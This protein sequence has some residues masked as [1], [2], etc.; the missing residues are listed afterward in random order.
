MSDGEVVGLEQLRQE[1]QSRHCRVSGPQARAQVPRRRTAMTMQGTRGPDGHEERQR[2]N[3]PLTASAADTHVSARRFLD[4][5]A[6]AITEKAVEP[7]VLVVWDLVTNA[8]R[9]AAESAPWT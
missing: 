2:R 5:L 8:L 6:P 4:D 7:V 3:R 9:T 1:E